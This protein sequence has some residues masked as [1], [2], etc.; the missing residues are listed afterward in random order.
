VARHAG[1]RPM[2]VNASD[3]R[4]ATVLTERIRRAMESTTLN[5]SSELGKTNI[6]NSNNNSS[7]QDHGKPNCLILDEIDGADAKGAIQALAD[8]IKAEI[9]AKNSK[10]KSKSAV[11]YLRRPIICICNHKYAPVLRPLLP[12]ALH[13][14]VEPPSP[15]RLVE[16]LK[17]ILNKE[18]VSLT[19]GASL[20]HQL[21][22]S[23]GGDIR[24]CLF[25]LQF[26]AAPAA[27]GERSLHHDLSQSL[28]NSLNGSGLKD[29]RN[30]V[31]STVN[32]VFRKIKSKTFEGAITTTK[33]KLA[34]PKGGANN[35]SVSRVMHAVEGFADDVTTINSIFVNV[36]RVSYIDPAFDRCWAAHELLSG[37]DN[38][39]SLG[40]ESY[41]TI[42]AGI[43]LL[44]R[45]EM[46]PQLTFSTREIAD[47]RFQQEANRALLQQYSD[48]LPVHQKASRHLQCLEVLS[49]EFI[50]LLL[51][52]LSAGEGVSS[53]SRPASSMDILTT[54]EREV[55]DRHVALLCALGLSYV[56]DLDKQLYEAPKKSSF[57]G[58]TI[59][60]KLDPPI[61]R[62][63]QYGA[64][65]NTTHHLFRRE[66]PTNMKML[67]A[68]QVH[69]EKFR[70]VERD[71]SSGTLAKTN[72]AR[73][74][75]NAKTKETTTEFMSRDTKAVAGVA[76]AELQGTPRKL[77]QLGSSA[78][79]P[80]AKRCKVGMVATCFF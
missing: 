67:L 44:C 48:G 8:I 24:S 40:S 32:T 18:K 74:V 29:D 61:D 9:P 5:L 57:H 39:N 60:M 75:R 54:T 15:A 52:I 36:L 13:F 46:K 25:T 10:Q 59:E 17:T 38:R 19:A 35:A 71:V 23:A 55:A 43:H 66:I 69:L 2:E 28:L 45:V 26:A 6:N 14:S 22:V 49:Q 63:V 80:D 4:S 12:F 31:V 42:A 68:Q 50:P 53:L 41:S 1:Y 21:V 78:G 64:L 33:S 70:R 58:Y 56:A 16:R 20:L 76:A 77:D 62:L 37:A 73:V 51:W 27:A 72:G 34:L 3:D 65:R 7:R 47:S 11:P 79:L 30:D